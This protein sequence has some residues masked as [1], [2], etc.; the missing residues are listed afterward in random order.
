MQRKEKINEGPRRTVLH[1][2]GSRANKILKLHG[3]QIEKRTSFCMIAKVNLC[4]VQILINHL[5]C[6]ARL[7]QSVERW[8]LNP[9]VVGSSLGCPRSGHYV[10]NKLDQGL[11]QMI[12][13]VIIKV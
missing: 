13:M 3:F 6:H 10:F 5:D 11:S 1:P 9:T 8:T 12:L 2:G 4:I 7:A